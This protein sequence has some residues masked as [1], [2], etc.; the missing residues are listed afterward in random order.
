M[1]RA[2]IGIAVIAQ[3]GGCAHTYLCDS[4]CKK[5]ARDLPVAVQQ[6]NGALFSKY[7]RALPA[8]LDAR[9]Y[10]AVA[11]AS[12]PSGGWQLHALKSVELEVWTQVGCAAAIVIA[13]CPQTKRVILFDDTASTSYIE[14]QN[15]LGEIEPKL[16]A[17]PS[18]LPVCAAPTPP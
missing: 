13:R 9:A 4:S 3:L 8:D 14:Q 7:H 5:R 15:L 17:R 16:P 1:R 18:P 6:A 10:L 2:L 11:R 12:L